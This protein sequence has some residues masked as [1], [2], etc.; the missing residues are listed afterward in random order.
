MFFSVQNKYDLNRYY[1][2][3][4]TLNVRFFTELQLTEILIIT[5]LD[6]SNYAVL[7][8]LCCFALLLYI[9]TFVRYI[10]VQYNGS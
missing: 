1:K 3:K 6:A 9:R 7:C 2:P 8:L 5:F 4:S 10:C